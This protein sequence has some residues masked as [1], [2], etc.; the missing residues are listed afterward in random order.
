[1]SATKQASIAAPAQSRFCRLTLDGLAHDLLHSS[2]ER[3]IH[4][5][6]RATPAQRLRAAAAARQQQLN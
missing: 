4:P 2:S 6:V 3:P 1:M 5:L